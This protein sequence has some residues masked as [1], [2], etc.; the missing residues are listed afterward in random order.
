[1]TG[2]NTPEPPTIALRGALEAQRP[3]LDELGEH[4][5]P[6]D[7]W[8]DALAPILDATAHGYLA[9]DAVDTAPAVGLDVAHRRSPYQKAAHRERVGETIERI[10]RAV[11]DADDV[12]PARYTAL[13]ERELSPPTW[14]QERLE[15]ADRHGPTADAGH[16]QI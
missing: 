12:T 8:R 15:R 6:P 7:A 1:M 3:V 4:G 10:G 11:R 16:I 13:I 9:R 2:P 14:V 5:G